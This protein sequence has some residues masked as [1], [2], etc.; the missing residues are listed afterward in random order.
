[1]H[2]LLPVSLYCTAILSA[3]E[4]MCGEGFGCS[5]R[6][7]LPA[8]DL[9]LPRH[10]P[11]CTAILSVYEKAMMFNA[12]LVDKSGM[13]RQ[14]CNSKRKRPPRLL[15]DWLLILE[16]LVNK[17]AI[18]ILALTDAYVTTVIGEFVKLAA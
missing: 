10:T 18:L 5:R 2:E 15:S 9:R 14:H 16:D 13:Q 1:V 7:R 17:C 4:R 12:Y 8:F 11:H 6:T 3:E